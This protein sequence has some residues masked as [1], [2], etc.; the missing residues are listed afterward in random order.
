MGLIIIVA[1]FRNDDIMYILQHVIRHV[2]VSM[3]WS[4][5]EEYDDDLSWAR[6]V[7]LGSSS[8]VIGSIDARGIHYECNNVFANMIT[9]R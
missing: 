8:V 9:T 3:L 5:N 7:G 2:I 4:N 6:F 1:S